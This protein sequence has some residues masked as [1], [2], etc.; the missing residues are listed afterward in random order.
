M[1]NRFIHFKF[2]PM[3]LRMAYTMTLLVLGTGYLFAM[4]QVF[5]VHAGRDGNP[6][7]SA[8][9]L[10][11]A[12]SGNPSGS[13]LESAL[14]GP[15]QGML[16]AEERQVVI[17]WVHDG[18]SK[19]GYE[20]KVKGI[21]DTRC[22]MCH[23]PATNPHLPDLTNL[24]GI[25]KVVVRDEG[26]SIATLV[27]V[28]HIHLFGITFIFFIISMIFSHSYLRP[29]WIK[30]VVIIVPFLSILLDI[31]SWY[32]TKMWPAF[33]WMV[34]GSGALMG[35]SFAIQWFTSMYQMWLYKPPQELIECE[36][37]LPFMGGDSAKCEPYRE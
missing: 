10:R 12:Y 13:R 22:V 18:A 16:P 17:E 11:I 20:A 15:M 31:T 36:G 21:M 34:I 6:S 23:S 30:C 24:D 5:E 9:D 7:L 27:R 35:I 14:H 8:N 29:V 2:L 37:Q 19:E 25:S 33:A 1:N 3:S 32:L 28:S 4:I 26:V